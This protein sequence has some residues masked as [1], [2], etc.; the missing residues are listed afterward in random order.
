[1]VGGLL[2]GE[3]VGSRASEPD[4]ARRTWQKDRRRDADEQRRRR[5]SSYRRSEKSPS[6][7]VTASGSGF[8]SVY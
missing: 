7:N 1:M 8:V 5:S 2:Q 6:A 4:E 3:V